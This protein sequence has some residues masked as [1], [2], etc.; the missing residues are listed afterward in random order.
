MFLLPYYRFQP[1]H[2]TTK[3]IINATSRLYNGAYMSWGDFPFDL[4]QQIFNESKYKHI[5]L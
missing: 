2:E 4:K 3:I 1:S 5:F